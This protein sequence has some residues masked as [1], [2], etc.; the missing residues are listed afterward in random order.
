MCSLRGMAQG[1]VVFISASP[2]KK[3]YSPKRQALLELINHTFNNN[4]AT[5][6]F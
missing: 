5:L 6:L 1:F 4:K 2:V 3:G